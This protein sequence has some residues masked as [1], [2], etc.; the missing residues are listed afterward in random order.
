MLFCGKSKCINMI[1]NNATEIT[2]QPTLSPRQLLHFFLWQTL[3][4][5]YYYQS[6]S[7]NVYALEVDSPCDTNEEMWQKGNDFPK[8]RGITGFG[9]AAV[10]N[11][12]PL[13]TPEFL[14]LLVEPPP[15][16]R[17]NLILVLHLRVS[18]TSTNNPTLASLPVA[19]LK[20]CFGFSVA[21]I[22]SFRLNPLLDGLSDLLVKLSLF[23]EVPVGNSSVRRESPRAEWFGKEP[24]AGAKSPRLVDNFCSTL[25]SRAGSLLKWVVAYRS[26]KETGW[27]MNLPFNSPL[28]HFYPYPAT[29][30]PRVII[31][32]VYT[33]NSLDPF[34]F[35]LT[36]FQL[37]LIPTVHIL[38]AYTRAVGSG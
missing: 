24:C 1:N 26:V 34:F 2:L 23:S 19:S 29:Q 31:S 4:T 20:P 13:K 38:Q 18:F 35:H 7:H 32:L 8:G 36:K 10:I 28:S 25:T 5:I 16:P 17:K 27:Q 14:A 6:T 9:L 30:R 22:L 15:P 33:P 11:H 21:K 12:W 37:W 3:P